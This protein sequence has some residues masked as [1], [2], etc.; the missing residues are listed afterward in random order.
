MKEIVL[1]A[2]IDNIHAATD[3][4]D[5]ELEALDC[6]MKAQLQLD[7]AIDEI[8]TNIASYAYPDGG[9]VATVRFDFDADA[10]TV[11]VAFIDSG[12]PFDPLKKADPDVTLSAEERSIGGLG[13]FMV[14]K[15]M[16]G[17]YYERRDGM[18]VLTIEKKI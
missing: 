8:F 11:R 4:V 1:D 13:I 5:A 2:V 6:P 7:V 12:V 17:M 15:T 9:G 3:F 18:N 10:R 16:D 14:K